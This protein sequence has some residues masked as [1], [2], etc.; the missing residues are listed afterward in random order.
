MAEA[1]A[2]S[3][4]GRITDYCTGI[5]NE[6][7]A[8]EWARVVDFVHSQGAVAGIQIAHAGRKASDDLY[9]KTLPAERGG[10]ET[11]GPSPIAVDGMVPPREMTLEDIS[12]VIADFGTAAKRAVQAGFK[13]IEIH[14]AHGY[15]LHE[16]ISPLSNQRTDDYGGI[17]ENRARFT[18]EVVREVRAS[19]PDEIALFIRFSAT[20][21][22]E[23]G[24]TPEETATISQWCAAE[25]VDLSDLSSGGLL[26]AIFIP[27]PPG[28][29]VPFAEIV[30]KKAN[31]LTA[32]VG[33]IHSPQ[34]AEEI[35][36]EEKADAIFLGRELMRNPRFAFQAASELGDTI[37]YLPDSYRGI[38]P[39]PRKD[40]H[41]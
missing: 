32:A 29:Q 37:D 17:L 8:E 9:Q 35:L 39:P 1:T 16:F 23:G 19:I 22:E 25:G 27:A 38:F 40:D 10:W 41:K 12:R 4:D 34:Q 3:P 18:M 21:W 36:Q 13:V 6:A 26:K 28:Y 5:W 11:I 14:A 7:Q 24:V 15:L 2:V 30:K 31:I 33:K 20:D